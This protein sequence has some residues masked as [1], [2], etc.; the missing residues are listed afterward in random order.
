MD[1]DKLNILIEE[2]KKTLVRNGVK[3]ISSYNKFFDTS[4][5]QIK[6]KQNDKK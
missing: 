4:K 1:N 5:K 2:L 6:E 3:D